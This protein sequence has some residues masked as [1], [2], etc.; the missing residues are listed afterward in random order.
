MEDE[1]KYSPEQCWIIW[2]LNYLHVN[3]KG[4]EFYVLDNIR[5][6]FFPEYELQQLVEL[7]Q[8]L[9]SDALIKVVEIPPIRIFRSALFSIYY[10][11][12]GYWVKKKIGK[13]ESK[14]L[15]GYYLENENSQIS[16]EESE[17]RIE[18]K[19]KEKSK[20]TI[21]EAPIK[22]SHFHDSDSKLSW[23]TLSNNSSDSELIKKGYHQQGLVGY[24]SRIGGYENEQIIVREYEDYSIYIPELGPPKSDKGEILGYCLSSALPLKLH[25]FIINKDQKL[26]CTN[27]NFERISKFGFDDE[28]YDGLY[29]WDRPNSDLVP[30]YVYSNLSEDIKFF[31][32]LPEPTPQTDRTALFRSDGASKTDEL[33]RD[34]LVRRITQSINE[35]F[36]HHQDAYTVLLNGEWGSG[37]S[38]MLNFFEEHL[39]DSDWKVIRYN[40]WENQ[41][42][43]DPWWIL[44]NSISQ[45]AS[46]ENYNGD[47]ASHRRW[48]IGIQFGN[49]ILALILLTVIV[50]S[51]IYLFQTENKF[52][53]STIASILALIASISTGIVGITNNFFY[54]NI[55]NEDLKER[56]T[57]HPFEPIRA[58]FNEIARENKL[59]IFIDDLDRCDVNATVSLLEGIQNL[60]KGVPVLY[61]IAADG[62]WVSHCFTERYKTF[63]NL[64]GNGC[65]IGDKFLQK[66]FQLTLNVPKPNQNY[67]KLYWDNLIDH[68]ELIEEEQEENRQTSEPVMVTRSLQE[69]VQK[70]D[71]EI[72]RKLDEEQI[73]F[74][75]K[76]EK[77]LRKFLEQGV[78]ENPR[79]MKRFINQYEVAR[80]MMIIE[81]NDQYNSDNDSMVRFLIFAMRYPTLA[82][83]LKKGE[84][85]KAQLLGE[86]TMG[87]GDKSDFKLNL[88]AKDQE[89]IKILLQ[90]IDEGLIKGAFFSI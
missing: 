7:I 24:I 40:A 3:K 4:T 8:I 55:S 52:E 85:T 30:L 88:T 81:G 64:S 74:D 89:E 79:Q 51:L 45:K 43:K 26:I 1:I 47:F 60:F 53:V 76:V 27:P 83:Q 63:S 22:I 70:Y 10:E 20:S 5:K 21:Q 59:A 9:K 80:Q 69:E 71:E 35:L 56:F 25:W 57:G 14:R 6:S 16:K 65:T 77:Y 46:D 2:Y 34:K 86:T 15:L 68:E 75:R 44:I 42:F 54:K 87:T 58:R 78:G 62:R 29:C 37:K 49:K 23:F 17:V 50:G 18:Q 19:Q 72:D 39:T 73:D 13:L 28:T 32:P 61:I 33:G 11:V 48:K 66:T 38:S 41:Q 12:N 31:T 84:I 90:D 82:D 36:D 67:L